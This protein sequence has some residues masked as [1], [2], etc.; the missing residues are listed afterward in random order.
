VNCTCG[1][2]GLPRRGGHKDWCPVMGGRTVGWPILDDLP[3]TGPS[4]AELAGALASILDAVADASGG[5]VED[6]WELP[7]R[8]RHLSTLVR[9]L[10]TDLL[11]S[12][13]GHAVE[14]AVALD[15]ERDRVLGVVEG[16]RLRI[17]A[18]FPRAQRDGAKLLSRAVHG[19]VL[20]R[21][22]A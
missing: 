12:Q 16:E 5:A 20:P 14:K 3:D 19:R 2:Q 13:T 7:D 8:V 17:E 1:P 22:A 10:R 6:Y 18:T 11:L 21:R 9:Q 15:Q 4:D